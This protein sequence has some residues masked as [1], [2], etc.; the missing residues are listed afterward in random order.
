M[1]CFFLL[2][3]G[4]VLTLLQ[5]AHSDVLVAKAEIH[6]IS[7]S[8]TAL[9]KKLHFSEEAKQVWG[10]GGW[11]KTGFKNFAKAKCSSLIYALF[12]FLTF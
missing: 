6:E 3:G 8:K 12:P 4:L 5:G 2:G 11:R 7:A 10:R 1:M 9:E